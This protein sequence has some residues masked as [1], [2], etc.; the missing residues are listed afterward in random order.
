MAVAFASGAP[1][2]CFASED[3]F[4]Y[5]CCSGAD[6]TSC[7]GDQYFQACCSHLALECMIPRP[8]S[9]SELSI[10]IDTTVA[11]TLQFFEM[12][13]AAA[14][15]RSALYSLES[16][17]RRQTRAHGRSLLAW[18]PLPSFY[19]Q[20]LSWS[21]LAKSSDAAAVEW[22]EA[23]A[24][25]WLPRFLED[26]DSI[27]GVDALDAVLRLHELASETLMTMPCC[28]RLVSGDLRPALTQLAR[29]E[30][31]WRLLSEHRGLW[32]CLEFPFWGRHH[33]SPYHPRASIRGH[34]WDSVVA[35]RDYR[36]Y[37]VTEGRE[38]G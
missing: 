24:C 32:R 1:L 4:Q 15:R 6:L 9:P 25:E 10:A 29:S 8:L 13:A 16:E 35:S 19:E 18:S 38:R 31:P 17:V 28:S 12:A 2:D 5:C 27:A 26:L 3:H 34:L 33:G 37:T 36:H 14:D 30:R 22:A 21:V 7:G 20:L 23:A 11:S